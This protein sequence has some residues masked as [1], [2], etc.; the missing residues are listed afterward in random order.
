MLGVL[1]MDVETC[2]R[3]YRVIAPTIFPTESLFSDSKLGKFLKAA[4]GKPRFD[5]QPFETVIKRLI[6]DHLKARSPAREHTK[7]GFEASMIQPCKVYVRRLDIAFNLWRYENRF[8][9]VTSEKLQKHF[10]FRSYKSSHGVNNECLIWEACR[11]TSA[12]PTFFPPMVIGHPPTAY[13]DG[14]LGYNNPIRPLMEEA[15]CVWP[16]RQFECILSIGTGVPE[17]RDVGKKILPLIET[18]K[19]IS[20]DTEKVAREVKK[21]MNSNIYFRFNVSHG[22]QQVAL[23][24]WEEFD[25]IKL[26]TED[27]LNEYGTDIELCASQIWKPCGAS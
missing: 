2:I 20:V 16:N 24:E 9:C 8:V 5:P 10:R 13:V 22:L 17:Y 3:E 27:Y 7:L 14:G 1:H 19:A 4:R 25:R 12:A 15:R 6:T 18:L 21:E 23:E 26:A 11:A